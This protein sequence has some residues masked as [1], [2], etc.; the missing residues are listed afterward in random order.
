MAERLKQGEH[1]VVG[2]D[3]NARDT[4]RLT[5][6]ATRPFHRYFTCIAR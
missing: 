2:F 3:F 6:A 4:A 1:D 5:E